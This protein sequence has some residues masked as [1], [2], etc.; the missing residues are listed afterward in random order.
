M[1]GERER[2]IEDYFQLGKIELS[3]T[4]EER[5][6]TNNKNRFQ[7]PPPGCNSQ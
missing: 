7:T 6:Q 4:K 2:K 3:P 1:M 5:P